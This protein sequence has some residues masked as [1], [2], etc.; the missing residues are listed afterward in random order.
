MYKHTTIYTN[1]QTTIYTNIQPY[2]QT[3]NHI[4]KQTTIY[5]NKHTTIYT[6][7]Q[8]LYLATIFGLWRNKFPVLQ[9]S[10]FFGNECYVLKIF[11]WGKADGINVST[12][13]SFT[14]L[15]HYCSYRAAC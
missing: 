3:Y 8:V 5:T 15:T 4:Y 13:L 1:K 7:E 14:K 2:I 11:P 12:F 6:N 9:L 10:M